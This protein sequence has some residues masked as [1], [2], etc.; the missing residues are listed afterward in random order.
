M[1]H[2][3]NILVILIS[4]V[5]LII[6]TSVLAQDDVTPTSVEIV[7]QM[8]NHFNDSDFEAA[9]VL[10]ADDVFI[11]YIPTVFQ[12]PIVSREEALLLYT[13]LEQF[14]P[15]VEILSQELIG[16]E[17]V[18]MSTRI[19]NNEMLAMGVKFLELT[20][21]YFVRDGLIIGATS[22]LTPESSEIMMMAMEA[23]DS[24]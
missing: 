13:Q 2:R 20:E 14:E 17:I 7:G 24:D 23:M 3:L 10:M 22:V 6:V 16:D 21:V 11:S 8:V 19:S 15:H 12:P 1:K 5:I 9:T 4:L 18:V